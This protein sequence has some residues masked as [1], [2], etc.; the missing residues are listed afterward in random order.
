M[1]RSNFNNTAQ[2]HRVSTPEQ[3]ERQQ[4]IGFEGFTA[5]RQP[6]IT[7]F[8]TRG[9]FTLEM[10]AAHSYETSVLTRPTQRH[11]PE[12]HLSAISFTEFRMLGAGYIFSASIAGSSVNN[13]RN[14]SKPCYQCFV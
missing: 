10:E 11:I 9:F 1:Y 6:M 12:D 5:V 3:N 7:L 4:Y 13:V 8:L 2:I 14:I